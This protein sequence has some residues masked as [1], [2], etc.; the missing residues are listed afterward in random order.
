MSPSGL[1]VTIFLS[2]LLSPINSNT[3]T[4]NITHPCAN[5][6]KTCRPGEE[7]F[8][9][10]TG[11]VLCPYGQH[12]LC[13]VCSDTTFHCSNDA[14][15][16]LTCSGASSCRSSTIHCPDF[17]ECHI[18]VTN[19]DPTDDLNWGMSNSHIIGGTDGDVTVSIDQSRG[20][21]HSTLN[22]SD[23]KYLN[24]QVYNRLPLDDSNIYCPQTMSSGAQNNCVVYAANGWGL[25]YDASFYAVE[26]FIDLNITCDWKPSLPYTMFEQC[27]GWSDGHK[28][29]MHCGLP[30]DR[31]QC[32]IDLVPNTTN[33]WNC[34]NVSQLCQ[35][36]TFEPT[37]SPTD[38]TMYPSAYPSVSSQSPSDSPTGLSEDPTTTPSDFPSVRPTLSPFQSRHVDVT[39]VRFVTTE[40][41]LIVQKDDPLLLVVICILSGALGLIVIVFII[42]YFHNK[43]NE[44]EETQE[45]S[46]KQKGE[47]HRLNTSLDLGVSHAVE[48]M[49]TPSMDN[50][51]PLPPELEVRKSEGLYSVPG[52]E[53][54]T[55]GFIGDQQTMLTNA[56]STTQGKQSIGGAIHAVEVTHGDSSSDDD[57]NQIYDD[58]HRRMTKG[59]AK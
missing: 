6:I 51:I 55:D 9:H 45:S 20:F 46:N 27:S 41:Y 29:S 12:A 35:S 14:H 32:V 25:L 5:T 15:C 42:C 24:L 56:G 39:I 31:S 16:H 34:A 21:W 59:C 28:P 30:Y 54:A 19:A 18:N 17:H 53:H 50:N 10:C 43:K 1:A 57:A 7:C 44:K 52:E 23:S 11:E 22:A 58:E 33:N 26:S 49:V 40:L 36:W 48:M 37:K 4:C 8:I 2:L 13:A 38:S 3:I 47:Q